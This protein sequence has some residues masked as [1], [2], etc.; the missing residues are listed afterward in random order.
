MLRESR[1][2]STPRLLGSI[3]AVS[4]CGMLGGFNRSS[5][6]VSERGCDE[7]IQAAFG[8]ECA[9]GFAIARPAAEGSARELQ[10]VLDG[11]CLGALE[12]GCCG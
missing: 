12:R 2:S 6:H 9:S 10:A 3:A 7:G 4:G 8:S 5:Q 11:D 1:A